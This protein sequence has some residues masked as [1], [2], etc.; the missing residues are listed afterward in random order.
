MLVSLTIRNFVLIQDA[1]LQ[2]GPGLTV[3]TG[4]TGAGKTLLTRALGL[5][6]GERAEDGL[7][8]RSG[9]EAVVQAVF[10]VGPEILKDI[11]A[12][13]FDLVALAPGELLI[14]RRLTS[15][16]RNRCFINDTAVTLTTLGEVV[17]RLLSF[18]GQHE[19]R[20]LLDPAYQLTVLDAW[21]GPDALALAAR[22]AEAYERAR[23]TEQRLAEISSSREVRLRQIDFL[24]FQVEEITAAALSPLEETE[25][26]SEQRRLSRAEDI[27]R[28]AAA[29]AELLG[30]SDDQTDAAALTARAAA[31]LS[32]V[33][34][35][36]DVLD[37]VATALTTVQYEL[38]E[39]SR[40]LHGLLDRIA[41]DP[42]RLD[43]VNSRLQ[44]YTEL[45]RKYGGSSSAALAYLEK[46]TEELTALEHVEEDLD[47]LNL[48]LGTQVTAA[49]DLAG[50]LSAARREAAPRLEAAVVAGLADLGMPQARFVVGFQ[51]REGWHELRSTGL[52]SAEF[53]L[54]ANPG[55]PPRSLART[56]SGGELSRVLLA[57]KS[58]LAG[59]GGAETLIFDEID[60]G[61]GGRTA[62]AVGEKI[63]ELSATSQVVVV[64]H[65]AQVAAL[66]DRHYVVEKADGEAPAITRLRLVEGE[67]VVEELCRMMGGHPED[68][69]AM[70]HAK[71]L[72]ERTRQGT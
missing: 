17:G 47:T 67:A 65:L 37:G 1:E 35:V 7:V 49:L 39:L 9:D 14:T 16:G 36:D 48:D 42:A 44:Q 56:A 21:A 25:L 60:A 28:H 63:R 61:I 13:I 40:E 72:W 45:A 68:T 50:R 24:R 26:L 3:L 41:V 62:T 38:S 34:G 15:Q 57:L 51:A 55:L 22:T 29:A 54:S 2:F 5:L 4:E 69:E 12:H 10:D 23:K 18:S 52:E 33:A 53:L 20:R 71:R 19:Y 8:G 58:A 43:V 70:A 6:I 66:A 27:L 32:A 59:V 46:A 11:P 31:H 30:G 64:T